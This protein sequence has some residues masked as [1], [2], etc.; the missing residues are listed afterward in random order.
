[1]L[2]KEENI[3]AEPTEPMKKNNTDELRTSATVFVEDFQTFKAI[4]N[5]KFSK[6]PLNNGWKEAI[7]LF[8]ESNKDLLKE[9]YDDL[10][11]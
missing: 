8:V 1:M 2:V 10:L 5:L 3:M 6:D 4:A 11:K 7:Q 9:S